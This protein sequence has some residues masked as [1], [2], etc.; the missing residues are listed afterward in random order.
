MRPFLT[1][2]FLSKLK[3]HNNS[4]IFNKAWSILVSFSSRSSPTS[5]MGEPPNKIIKITPD[6]LL[7]EKL[8]HYFDQFSTDVRSGVFVL[9]GN[10][11]KQYIFV[12]TIGVR[13]IEVN[14]LHCI[15]L[16]LIT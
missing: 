6:E 11:R 8:L 10:F 12:P 15:V 14:N 2:N 5:E 9:Q 4:T 13:L 7:K 3:I 1:N 16:Y